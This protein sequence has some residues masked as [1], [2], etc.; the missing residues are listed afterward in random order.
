MKTLLE[1]EKTHFEGF[2]HP[3]LTALFSLKSMTYVTLTPLFHYPMLCGRVRVPQFVWVSAFSGLIGYKCMI[4][5]YI[6]ISKVTSKDPQNGVKMVASS[7]KKTDVL[8]L[9]LVF[10]DKRFH[11]DYFS[12]HYTRT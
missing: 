1:G 10:F 3:L 11:N 2:L 4:Y 7:L 6:V 12:P 5:I 8:T 9:A